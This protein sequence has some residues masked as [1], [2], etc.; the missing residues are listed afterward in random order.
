MS[1]PSPG[2]RKNNCSP[3]EKG[4]SSC[5]C[6]S[7]FKIYLFVAV[8]CLHCCSWT[9]SNCG[10]WRASLS[11]PWA[12]FWLQWLLSPCHEQLLVA[13]ASLSLPWAASGCGGFSRR[14]AGSGRPWS[15]VAVA[16]GLQRPGS[17]VALHRLGCPIFVR[18]SV[19][20]M[21]PVSPA[22]AV[23]FPTTGPAVKPQTAFLFSFL[24]EVEVSEALDTATSMSFEDPVE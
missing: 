9:V 4:N 11:L 10:Q 1:N 19:P 14:G 17:V 6:F 22:L 18:S 3:A 8:L 15:S 21:E 20:G 12:G 2:L 16:H 23:G 24:S 7:F 13:V 5:L